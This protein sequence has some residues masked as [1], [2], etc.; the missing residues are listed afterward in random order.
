M[1]HH[2]KEIEWKHL[3]GDMYYNEALDAFVATDK[4]SPSDKY[5]TK[6]VKKGRN[7]WLIKNTK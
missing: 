7:K 5:L 1:T 3:E 2:K 6:V 4:E